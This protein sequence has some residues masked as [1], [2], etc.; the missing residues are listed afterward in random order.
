MSFGRAWFAPSK[1]AVF[2]GY[3]RTAGRTIMEASRAI[4]T[5]DKMLLLEELRLKASLP[6]KADLLPQVDE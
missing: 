1:R 5:A 6:V 3:L 4:R 2:R